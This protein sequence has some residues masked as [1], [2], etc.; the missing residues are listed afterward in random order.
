MKIKKYIFLFLITCTVSGF[1]QNIGFRNYSVEDGLVSN[2]IWSINQDDQGYMW[3]GTKNGISR[4]DGYN[5]K[6]YQFNI[7][8]STSIKDNFI[9]VIFKLDESTFWM[10]TGKGIYILNLKDEKFSF[11]KPTST[12]LI[13]DIQKDKSGKVWVAT[14]GNGVYSYDLNSKQ[15][16]NYSKSSKIPLSFNE[17]RK[18]VIT[19]NGEV[20]MG[21]FG[22][23]I[24]VLSPKTGE[25]QIFNSKNN[26][27]QSNYI[28]TLYQDKMEQIWAGT[29][30]GGLSLYQK[31]TDNFKTFLKG[32]AENI[33]N[34]I[35]RAIFQSDSKKLYVGTEG[36]LN[37]LDLSTQ[38]FTNYTHKISDSRGLSDNAIYSIFGDKSNGIWIGTYFGGLNYF[39]NQNKAFECFYPKAAENSLSGGAV[40]SFLEDSPGNFWIGTEDG[41]LNY[42][43][44]SNRSF[45]HYPFNKKQQHL[46]YNNIHALYKDKEGNIWIGTFSGGLNI[47]NVKTGKVKVYK[48]NPN[49]PNSISSDNVFCIYEDRE[50]RIWVGTTKGLNLYNSLTDSFLQIKDMDMQNKFI[51]DIYEDETR[52]IWFAVYG[53]GLYTKNTRTNKWQSYKPDKKSNSLSSN[54]IVCLLDDHNGNL[55]IGTEGGG[56]NLYNF[57]NKT[58]QTFDEKEGLDANVVYGLLQ[59]D[60]RTIWISTNNGLYSYSSQKKLKH[61]TKWDNLQSKQFNYKAYYKSA[62]G[63]LY[64]GGIKG[65]NSFYP[66]S[67]NIV[68]TKNKVVINNIQL[69]N[70]DVGIGNDKQ[71][72]TNAINYTKQ[73]KIPYNQSV[74]SFEFSALN[75]KNPGK[76]QYAYILQ[77]FDKN[78][79][80]IGN[81]R[82]ATYTNLSPGS[83]AFKV[84]ATSIEGNWDVPETEITLIIKPPFYRTNLAYFLYSLSLILTI[85]FIRK[86]LIQ[87]NERK[88]QMKLE[89]LSIKN[90]KDFY[91]KKIEFFTAMAHE[92]RTPL[93]LILAPLEKLLD[94]KKMDVDEK[95]QLEIMDEN[96]DR[97]MNL[98]NQ[99][100]DFRR[101]ESDIYEIHKEEIDLVALVQAIYSRFSGMQY[102]KGIRFSL[103]TKVSS[104]MINA[105]PEALTKI[106]NNL[107]INAFKFAR[108]KI[109]ISI[110]EPF[111]EE[112]ES[113]FVVKVEDDGIGIPKTD[114]ENVFDKFF[115][116][117][118]NGNQYNNLGGTGIGLALAK[119]LTEK[120]GGSLTVSSVQNIQTTFDVKIPFDTIEKV[121]NA[122]EII[123]LNEIENPQANILLVE[124]DV[125]LSEFFNMS[126]N[127]EGYQVFKAGNGIEALKLLEENHVDLI[128]SDVM[129]PEMDG[130]EF[131]RQLKS[132]LDYSH[133]PLILLTAKANSDAEIE[134]IESGADAYI[135]KPFK[136]KHVMAVLKN[137][138]DAHERLKEKFSTMPFTQAETLTSNSRDKKFLERIEEI[139]AARITDP[140]LSVEELSKEV[141]MS[142]SSL[143]KKLKSLSGHVP[144][145][146]IRLVRLKLA[147]KLL[148][149]REHNISEIGYLTGFNSH[150]YF[151]KCFYQQFKL[152]P[153]EF[154]DKYVPQS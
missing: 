66:D 122:E 20:W 109:K 98:V 68:N 30:G 99:L 22:G 85:I 90:E 50:G 134:G 18:L 148:L 135:T 86:Y 112:G 74:I 36:G 51:Y 54:K 102:N 152:T 64:F 52:T 10:G 47:Y 115:K 75:Y 143:H 94:S 88:N 44:S 25:I 53:S 16:K 107:I 11:F 133:I 128:L 70:K 17:V 28:L 131:C 154:A 96:S 92:I 138:M 139:I 144:N 73:V 119:S 77:G 14:A 78:W 100:L 7:G 40:S 101:I 46:S 41:G 110:Q 26:T 6:P 127:Q 114:V 2:T 106:F 124:D 91:T 146:F 35:V 120:H 21:T 65:F 45:K 118:E 13:F 37:I 150:S 83:Y 147:A 116:V 117:S 123:P 105:D 15:I 42:F 153:S 132:N 125:S 3:F 24:N 1:A 71:I 61:Y 5:F 142:R 80:D 129:M 48:S 23:G 87:R 60:N 97:L 121:E 55:W 89:R 33:N 130:L 151:S 31:Q 38:K 136:W 111:T 8:D 32:G 104:L 81:Q 49:D 137:L 39:V 141:A 56:L 79:N 57:Q 27:L 63:K 93:S 67:I 149:S 108:T 29:F 145:E 140:Q 72:L 103:N 34:N 19:D 58:F 9:H 84:K 113:F 69:L 82:K 43:N 126:L 12:N 95:A 4:F 76:I 59:D 62:D